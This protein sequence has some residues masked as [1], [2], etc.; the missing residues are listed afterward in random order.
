MIDMI[1]KKFG[2]LT[3][4]ERVYNKKNGTFFKCKCDCGN[5][6]I[7]RGDRLRDGI[8]HHCGCIN[9]Y[10]IKRHDER[11]YNIWRGMKQ[12]CFNKN[13]LKYKNYG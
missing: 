2:E 3:V 5:E 12:R 6:T 10:R 11:L 7:A 13:T 1:N 8:T 9:I 4:L